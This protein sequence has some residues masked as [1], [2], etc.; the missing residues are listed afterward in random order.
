MFS[1]LVE[2]SNIRN[3]LRNWMKEKGIETRPTFPCIHMMPI[4][5]KKFLY[6]PV[7]EDISARGINLPSYPSLKEEDVKEICKVIREYYER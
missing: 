6:L 7:A 4:Y 1:I 3:S 2:S 5:N